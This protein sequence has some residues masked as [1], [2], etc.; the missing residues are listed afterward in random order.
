MLAE[1][2]GAAKEQHLGIHQINDAVT[3]MDA[4]TQQN[5]ALAEQLAASA[6]SL[7]R[8]VETVLLSTRVFRL[9]H[10][11]MTESQLDATNLRKAYRVLEIAAD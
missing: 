8:Q 11:E 7:V 5:A 10:G 3:Q 6:Q 2:S 9:Q 4:L 1:I